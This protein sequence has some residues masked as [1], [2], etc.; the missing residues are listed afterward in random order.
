MRTRTQFKASFS[1]AVS[2]LGNEECCLKANRRDV[3]ASIKVSRFAS[4]AS[5]VRRISLVEKRVKTSSVDSGSSQN[6]V[7]V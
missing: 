1:G 4:D 6:Y 7:G 5:R 3:T 2:G